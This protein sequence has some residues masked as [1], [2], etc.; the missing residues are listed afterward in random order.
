ML[1]FRNANRTILKPIETLN[2]FFKFK[3]L[4]FFV[5]NLYDLLTHILLHYN[6]EMKKMFPVQSPN[7]KSN[8]CETIETSKTDHISV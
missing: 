6:F 5:F 8:Q 3:Y 7:I 4:S 1:C 2:I